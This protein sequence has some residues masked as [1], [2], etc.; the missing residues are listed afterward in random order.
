MWEY[1]QCAVPDELYHHGIKGM[2][3]GIRRFQNKNGYLTD[4]GRKR[5]DVDVDKAKERVVSA[6][7]KQKAAIIAYNSATAGGM[8]YNKEAA[9][10]LSKAQGRVK[11]AKEQVWSEKV[12]QKLNAEAGNKSKR[13]LKLEE[14]YK[15]K[16]MSD[17]EAEIAAYKR[18]RTEKIIAVTAGVA[19]TAAAAYV[20]YKHYDKVADRYIKAGTELQNISANPDRGVSDAF[21]FSMTKGDNAKYRG[22]YGM[23]IANGGK[24]VYETK[25][26][27]KSAMKV[28][29]QKSA[30]NALADL[31]KND[32]SYMD[33]L[34][35]HF[36][37]SAGRYI[38]PKQNK[39]ITEGLQSLRKGKV[40]SKVYEAL[41]LSLVD[42]SLSTSSK[43]NS[44]FYD[45]LKK[46]GY[47]AIVDVND[48]KYSG[49]RSA[50]PM[51]AFNGAS[52]TAVDRVREVGREEMRKAYS[53]GYMD[54]TLKSLAPSATVGAGSVGL[55]TA[56]RKAADRRNHDSIV[57]EYKR[58]HPNTSLS[59]NQILDEYYS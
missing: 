27:V 42:H 56:G 38:N 15:A 7:K 13:R 50:K 10:A 25:I 34:A 40:D 20:A 33:T 9:N 11:Y 16:G 54:I 41:N 14:E 57:R 58:K 12:K 22:I 17:E 35:E 43:V 21:Y 8:I 36:S 31:V 37:N 26:G 59:Y 24:R 32:P 47:D 1:N 48:K 19:V 3:W 44:G 45:K 5:Y 28:A 4:A 6:K 39:V 46:M 2:H 53:K 29:S 51:I 52:K 55:I 49:F 18:A 23:T 30:T